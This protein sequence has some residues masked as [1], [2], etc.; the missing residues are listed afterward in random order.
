MSILLLNLRHV[1]EDEAREVRELLEQHRIEYFETPPSRWG[2]S[3]GGIWV[4]R[5]DQAGQA[6]ELFQ[7]Y[8]QERL[9]RVRT[10][11]RQARQA[12]RVPTLGQTIRANPLGTLAIAAIIGLILWVMLS[13]FLRL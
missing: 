3:A 5:A 1:P 2:I 7:R 4:K 12:G 6:R 11:Y 10:E 9:T 8:Q 13:P